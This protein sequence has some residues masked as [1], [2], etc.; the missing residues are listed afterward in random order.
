M[1]RLAFAVAALLMVSL[2]CGTE[3]QEIR[4]GTEGAYHPYNYVADDGELVGFEI[5][6]GNELCRRA[7]LDCTWVL[8]EWDSMIPNL[9]AGDF[10][11]IM[12]GMSITDERDELIDFS[13]AYVPPSPSVYMALAGAGDES[14]Q[15]K[16]GAQAATIHLD[17]L[18]EAGVTPL[19]YELAEDLVASVLSGE[20][21]VVLVDLGF[22][23]DNIEHSEE[24]L[25]IVGPEVAIDKGIGIGVREEDGDLKAKFDEAIGE[26]KRDGTLNELIEKWF[27]SEAETF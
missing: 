13:E 25:A 27:G 3:P 23:L 18:L 21:D 11:T 5:E 15:G 1:V 24:R 16:V 4:M 26:M 10:D 6:L 8:N 9:Q 2:A 17:Y 7:D 20:A 14:L 22:A 19:E 12:A